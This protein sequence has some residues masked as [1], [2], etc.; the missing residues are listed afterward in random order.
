MSATT[1]AGNPGSSDTRS[2]AERLRMPLMIGGVLIVAIGAGLFWLFGGR[3]MSTDDAY[4]QAARASISS[5]VSGQVIEIAVHDNQRV[6]KG[7]LLFRLDDA[8]YRIAVEEAQARLGTA[9]LQVVA[10]KSTYQQQ[11][12]GLRSAQDTLA[13]QQ[14][15]YERQ[16]KLLASGIA[17]KSQFDQAQHALDAARQSAAGAQQQAG[18]VLAMLDGKPDLD[19]DQ[20][21]SVQQA[22][23]E[24]DRAQLNLAYTRIVAPYDGIVA[25]V[26]QLQPGDHINA[27]APVFALISSQDVWIEANF[28][29]DQLTHM[30]PGQSAEIKIDTYS[31]KTFKAKVASL[32]PGTGSQFSALPPENAT[33]NWVK[34]VQRLP[35]RLELEDADPSLPLHTG[36]SATVKVDTG[37]RRSLSG[38]EQH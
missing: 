38:D 6:K 23:A 32:A 34:V 10:G 22:Q 12:A 7:D 18:A 14:R 2:M 11:L 21:P 8:P 26:E 36:L 30:R 24:L 19:P 33:G 27:A 4:V 31:G 1:A 20:H 17:S 29:E 9:R 37:H 16:K 5:N 3:Y 35:V 13:Y 15:E 25:K 28:K